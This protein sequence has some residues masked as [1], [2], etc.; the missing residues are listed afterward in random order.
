MICYMPFSYIED[1][2]LDKLT[3]AFGT[4]TMY[5]PRPR[6]VSDH[7]LAAVQG[8]KLDLRSVP[9]VQAEHLDQAIREF[10]AWADLH[11][12][13]IADLAGLS[14]S[15][16]GRLPLVDETNPTSIGDQIRHFGEQNGREAVD[17]VFQAAL[18]L[19]MAQQ[20]DQQQ[21]AVL[22]DLGDVLTME[23]GMLARL[24]GDA[25]GMDHEAGVQSTAGAGDQSDSGAF[26]TA[27]RV[28]CWAELVCK[29]TGSRT[30]ILYLTS[31]PA[32]LEHL[33]NHFDQIQEPFGISLAIE[34]EEAGPSNPD[35]IEALKALAFAD[36]PG[37]S[38]ADCFQES[39]NA[40]HHI[41][42]TVYVLAGISP[43][44]FP[45]HLV[46]PGRPV[47]QGMHTGQ[48]P[49]NTLIGLMAK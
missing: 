22:R 36:N 25:E 21:A 32:V 10:K 1:R 39:R 14:K 30:S 16:Q 29:D 19:S 2:L 37:A 13:D 34:D 17:P 9:G 47:E 5:C 40:A 23:Q 26:M 48:G 43:S 35:V 49:V 27:K 7:M 45:Q 31:S 18:F 24:A 20:Y 3:A 12:G 4:V 8:M 38:I 46:S 11:G 15:M 41:H 28:Q 6:M 33:Q 42:L 44:V